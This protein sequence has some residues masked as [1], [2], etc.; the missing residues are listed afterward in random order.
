MAI[1][2]SASAKDGSSRPTELCTH[3]PLDWAFHDRLTWLYRVGHWRLARH[4]SRLRRALAEAGANIVVNYVSS[5][6]KA[7]ETAE[8]VQALGRKAAVVK[9]DVSEEADVQSMMEFIGQEFG[10][11]DVVVSNAATGG[12]KSLLEATPRAFDNAMRINVLSLIHLVQAGMHL[13]ERPG[14]QGLDNRSKIIALSSAGSKFALPKYGLIGSSKAALESLVR[15]L[16]LELGPRGVN[17]NV[18]Q[19]GLV[20]TDSAR[21]LPN[22]EKLLEGRRARSL[23]GDALLTPDDVADAV[24]FLASPLSDQIQGTTLTVDGGATIRA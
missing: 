19:A 2:P 16:T 24:A 18:V 6:S 9:A 12:F 22:A 14:P 17:V 4:R 21:L 3:F 23:T 5:R 1:D 20:D 8:Q 7:E 11:L 10:R 13:L 15:H